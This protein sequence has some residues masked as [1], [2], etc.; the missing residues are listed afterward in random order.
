MLEKILAKLLNTLTKKTTTTKK[1]NNNDNNNNNNNKKR[2]LSDYR[3]IIIN[4]SKASSSCHLVAYDQKI[5]LVF[6]REKQ[7]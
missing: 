5:A 1:E 2:D 3:P 6:D 4:L 7:I